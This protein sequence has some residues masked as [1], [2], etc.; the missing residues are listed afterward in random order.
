[1]SVFSQLPTDIQQQILTFKDP[2]EL[3]IVLKTYPK[4]KYLFESEHSLHQLA[5][6]Y[7]LPYFNGI[8]LDQLCK[9]QKMIKSKLL[10]EA[11]KLGDVRVIEFL[12]Q[13]H[14]RIEYKFT[15][16]D[17][18]WAMVSAAKGG[19]IEIIEMMSKLGANKYNLAMDRAAK[20]GHIEIV[21]MMR[22]LGANDY[23]S[24]M[25]SA[26]EG[27]HIEI[28]EMMRGLGADKY[29]WA[30]ARAAKKGHIEIVEMMRGLGA[31]DYDWAMDMA[32]EGGHIEIVE[33]M[34]GLDADD[35]NEAM[36]SAA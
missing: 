14:K 36:A 15:K 27:G 33:M 8:T 22:D 13:P 11:S 1:M 30:M 12:I 32:A 31:N 19:H 21:K 6:D 9:Y 34:R 5:T 25:A 7:G 20:G 2:C 28:V 29:N 23:D 4:F 17:Y 3:T 18:N 10:L 35:Y 26:A 24:A 16:I